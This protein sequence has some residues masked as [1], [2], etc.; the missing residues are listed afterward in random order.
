M[1]PLAFAIQQQMFDVASR[2]LVTDR[3]LGTKAAAEWAT[4]C[5]KRAFASFAAPRTDPEMGK[6]VRH[7]RVLQKPFQET[8]PITALAELLTL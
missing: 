8:D 4:L 2:R 5:R 1:S 7:H 3:N 6:N